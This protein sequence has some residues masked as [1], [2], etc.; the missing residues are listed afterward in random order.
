MSI[1]AKNKIGE[2][3]SILKLNFQKK[4]ILF[5]FKTSEIQKSS[6]VTSRNPEN[7]KSL[8]KQS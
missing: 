7:F 2:K 1:P 4:K 6:L 3:L 8:Q 5:D